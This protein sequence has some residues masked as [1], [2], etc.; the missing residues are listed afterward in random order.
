MAVMAQGRTADGTG[1]MISSSRA[2]L[3]ASPGPD[4]ADAAHRA[5]D[6]MRKSVNS[7]RH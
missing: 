3:Y 4:F 6:E 5:A 2:I 7:F 1:L